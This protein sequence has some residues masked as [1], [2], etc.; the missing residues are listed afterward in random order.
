MVVAAGDRLTVSCDRSSVAT[1][2][3]DA[4]RARFGWLRN[5]KPTTADAS[6]DD[7][8]TLGE[9]A[10]HV[11]IYLAFGTKRVRTLDTERVTHIRWKRRRV[12]N[13]SSTITFNT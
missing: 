7:R 6:D 5:G 4:P 1:V 8:C 12:D 9:Y 11:N 13:A 10:R 3:A 2:V